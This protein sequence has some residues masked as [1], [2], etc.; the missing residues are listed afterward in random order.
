LAALTFV[1]INRCPFPVIFRITHNRSGLFGLCLSQT[2]KPMHSC[3]RNPTTASSNAL[4]PGV[5]PGA[6]ATQFGIDH[7]NKVV[8]PV[9]LS[10]RLIPW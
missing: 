6:R 4:G 1:R 8:A 9:T 2:E 3:S 5:P 10:F 7:L